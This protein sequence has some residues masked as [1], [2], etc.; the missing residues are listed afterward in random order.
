MVS[1]EGSY[2][3]NGRKTR[4]QNFLNLPFAS[5]D[6]EYE[7]VFIGIPY[8]GGTSFRSGTRMGPRS[9]RSESGVLCNYNPYLHIDPFKEISVSDYG[10]ITILPVPINDVF[11][12]IQNEI[13]P[14]VN[15]GTVPFVCGGDHSVTLP[16]LREIKRKYG[17]VNL[18]HLDAHIDLWDSELGSS[19]NH[20]N[21][22]SSAINED[23]LAD[24]VQYGIRSSVY[25]SQD[26]D[27][28][29]KFGIKSYGI[30]HYH[31]KGIKELTDKII[32]EFD[33]SVPLYISWDI[34]VVDPAYAPATGTP[35][36]GGISSWDAIQ[37][38]RALRDNN[39]VGFDLVEISPP[40]DG[41]GNITSL[42]GA[43]IIFE[44]MSSFSFNLKNR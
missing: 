21:W 31:N 8:D 2:P 43:N 20:G 17:K 28:P 29:S 33:K 41:P 42:L 34:D 23:L 3:E 25:S 26:E 22:L 39:I 5:P 9:V 11:Q 27:L 14:I 10:D 19:H 7:A 18:L 38:S 1:G 35:E 36:V 32:K 40:Y 24:V 15:K 13:R 16:L 6:G 44:A 4:N 37:I 12:D 30:E